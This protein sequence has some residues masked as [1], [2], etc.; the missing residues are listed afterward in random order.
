[1]L[2]E[3][4]ERLK[5]GDWLVPISSDGYERPA[6]MV[7]AIEQREVPDDDKAYVTIRVLRDDMRDSIPESARTRWYRMARYTPDWDKT[8]L[9]TLQRYAA[10]ADRFGFD[11]V[12]REG[13]TIDLAVTPD[14][15]EEWRK[16]IQVE[17]AK[18][19]EAKNGE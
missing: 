17:T 6:V 12:P 5:V 14:W 4:I 13:C 19:Q 11:M 3:D 2:R 9:E 10:F 7:T 16:W 15:D 8:I 18:L 1:M